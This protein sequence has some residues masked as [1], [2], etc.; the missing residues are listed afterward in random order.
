MKLGDIFN[1]IRDTEIDAPDLLKKRILE[2]LRE[3]TRHD[4]VIMFWRTFA[5]I[6]TI[7][8][9]VFASYFV[10]MRPAGKGMPPAPPR[11]EERLR[12]GQ[13]PKPEFVTACTGLNVGAS[14]SY[15]G[16]DGIIVKGTCIMTDIPTGGQ[17]LGCSTDGKTVPKPPAPPK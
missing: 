1:E 12:Q 6:S 16:R 10:F 13:K 8:L 11:G 9:V 15:T 7:L 14:C 4:K 17:E 2:R 5:I 3:E